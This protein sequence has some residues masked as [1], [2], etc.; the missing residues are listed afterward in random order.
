VMNLAVSLHC[1][2]GFLLFVYAQLGSYT[3]IPDAA[4]E[5][6]TA[7]RESACQRWL[8]FPLHGFTWLSSAYF[9]P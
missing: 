9:I 4:H 8:P 5:P 6:L 3:C 1:C 7:L 2:P